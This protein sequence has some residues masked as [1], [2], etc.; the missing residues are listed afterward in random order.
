M[1][2][3]IVGFGDGIGVSQL[4]HV[5]TVCTSLQRDNLDIMSSLNF[6]RRGALADAQ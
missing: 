2:Q 5:Q 1:R 4:D 3:E 6:Y